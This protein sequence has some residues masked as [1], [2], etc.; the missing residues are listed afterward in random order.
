MGLLEVLVALRARRWM[1]PPG[2]SS[3]RQRGG[4]GRGCPRSPSLRRPSLGCPSKPST[5]ARLGSAC[6][7]RWRAGRRR[8]GH[9]TIARL[10]ASAARRATRS[11]RARRRRLPRQQPPA[12]RPSSIRAARSRP[13]RALSSPEVPR[14][15]VRDGRAAEPRLPPVR[16]RANDAAPSADPAVDAPGPCLAGIAM[17]RSPACPGPRVASASSATDSRSR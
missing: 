13:G 12:P 11:A 2:M 15:R 10:G 7:G 4:R 8:P 14:P 16:R 6:P 17:I 3:C 1:R 9:R 5:R